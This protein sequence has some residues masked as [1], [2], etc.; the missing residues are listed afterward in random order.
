MAQL[1]FY[2]PEEVEA[3]IRTAAQQEGKSLS[4]FLAELVK[5]HLPEKK[6]QKN[7]FSEFFGNNEANF[8]EVERALPQKRDNL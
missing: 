1:N 4:S 5:K 3:R 8:S 6:T 7:Y 2:V